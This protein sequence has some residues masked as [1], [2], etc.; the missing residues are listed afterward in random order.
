M[1]EG[2]W[3]EAIVEFEAASEAFDTTAGY[4]RLSGDFDEAR[5]ITAKHVDALIQTSR[6]HTELGRDRPALEALDDAVVVDDKH[7]PTYAS[8]AIVHTPAWHGWRGGKGRRQGRGARIRHRP[9]EGGHRGRQE[10]PL[11]PR[12]SPG[13]PPRWTGDVPSGRRLPAGPTPDRHG[14][15]HDY[16]QHLGGSDA[17]Q[18][19]D[20]PVAVSG[21]LALG[22]DKL[23]AAFG[24]DLE[25]L[26][27]LDD[28][29]LIVLRHRREG[30]AGRLTLPAV[31]R[32]SAPDINVA[33]P[34]CRNGGSLATLHSLR[35]SHMFVG[36]PATT[37]VSLSSISPHVVA[38]Q[39]G[40][41]GNHHRPV[42][43]PTQPRRESVGRQVD[44]EGLRDLRQLELARRVE[45]ARLG[46]Y[47][48]RQRQLGNVAGPRT[49][50]R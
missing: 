12:G 10:R 26:Q 1:A 22:D 33:R 44:L 13:G 4:R 35:V 47:R 40:E 45:R 38:L 2:R 6:A 7:A 21:R 14:D 43:Q 8:R 42:L 27:E 32:G 11:S 16:H 29:V 49:R 9:V 24:Q 3:E 41:D 39:V 23:G 37:S 25:R 28:S 5:E 31:P 20:R 17:G 46:E 18:Y 34:W 30:V 15:Q 48:T 36:T 50:S 19:P